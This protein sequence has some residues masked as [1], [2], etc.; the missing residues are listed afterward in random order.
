MAGQDVAVTIRKSFKRPDPSV[1]SGFK[2]MFS[3]NVV[4][5]QGRV[6]ALDYRIKPVGKYSV[7]FGTALTVDAGPR[8][9]LGAWAAL[10]AAQ[11]GDVIVI[12]TGGHLGCSVVGDVF[13]GMARNAGA[14]AVVTDGVVRD[15]PGIDQVGIPVFAVG[16]SPNSPWK[17]G[18]AEIGFSVVM[19]GI[20]VNSGDILVGDSDGVAVVSREKA[21]AV[22]EEL[23]RVQGKEALMDAEV[24]AGKRVP[25]WLAEALRLKGVHDADNA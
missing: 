20:T 9:N 15:V 18:P 21:A 8:D 19:G 22:L 7:F 6:G 5:A 17:N 2:S 10:G 3:G 16:V 1:V 23:K 24:K 4:D 25:G 11:P 12:A 14:V 13:V